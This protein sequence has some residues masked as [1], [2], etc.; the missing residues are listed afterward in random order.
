[1]TLFQPKLNR[2]VAIFKKNLNSDFWLVRLVFYK[3][4]SRKTRVSDAAKFLTW[5]FQVPPEKLNSTKHQERGRF[6]I[7]FHQIATITPSWSQYIVELSFMPVWK[8]LS[9]IASVTAEHALFLCSQGFWRG[10]NSSAYPPLPSRGGRYI[11]W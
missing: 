1:M 11:R 8:Q 4:L 9:P 10:G 3:H 6:S 2:T 5:V 7:L